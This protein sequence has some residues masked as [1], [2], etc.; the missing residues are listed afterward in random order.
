MRF[1]SLFQR[2]EAAERQQWTEPEARRL[3]ERDM[4]E[5]WMVFDK[6]ASP[7]TNDELLAL[8]DGGVSARGAIPAQVDRVSAVMNPAPLTNIDPE[9]LIRTLHTHYCEALDSF[10]VMSAGSWESPLVSTSHLMAQARS[11][12]PD[13]GNDARANADSSISSLFF[14][15]L[16]LEDAIGPLVLDDA[17]NRADMNL[18][19]PPE[20]LHLFAPPEYQANAAA[21]RRFVP[22]ELTRREHHTLAIDSP[23]PEFSAALTLRNGA[24]VQAASG[25]ES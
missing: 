17:L 15:P 24:G 14:E 11:S 22:P 20:I 18:D 4:Q 6:A 9:E 3:A 19:T 13:S 2:V 1:P 25:S 10:Q 8:F 12:V 16:R 7:L 21:R 5:H 23:L